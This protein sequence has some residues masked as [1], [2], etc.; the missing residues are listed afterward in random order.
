MSTFHAALTP[1]HLGTLQSCQ[2]AEPSKHRRRARPPAS[3]SVPSHRSFNSFQLLLLTAPLAF[4][5]QVSPS[6]VRLR[7]P[8]LVPMRCLDTFPMPDSRSAP[9][10]PRSAAGDGTRQKLSPDVRFTR[11]T[12]QALSRVRSRSSPVSLKCFIPCLFHL[13]R[14]VQSCH[15]NIRTVPHTALLPATPPPV[16]NPYPSRV[17]DESDHADKPSPHLP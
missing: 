12:A 14:I 9:S 6:K 7:S 2:A 11:V 16:R 15:C 17:P 13:L 5:P 3:A 8:V 4:G 1:Q 10:D